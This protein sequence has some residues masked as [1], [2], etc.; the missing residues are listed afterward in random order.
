MEGGVTP[1]NLEKARNNLREEVR[2]KVGIDIFD[3]NGRLKAVEGLFGQDNLWGRVEKILATS[4]VPSQQTGSVEQNLRTLE[5]CRKVIWR[6]LSFSPELRQ[7]VDNS[8]PPLQNFPWTRIETNPSTGDPLSQFLWTNNNQRQSQM[9]DCKPAVDTAPPPQNALS[10]N[11]PNLA[12]VSNE[13]IPATAR[14][15]IGQNQNNP[16]SLKHQ[17]FPDFRFSLSNYSTSQPYLLEQKPSVISFNSD[18]ISLLN[19]RTRNFRRYFLGVAE[20]NRTKLFEPSGLLE[21]FKT[22]SN[23]R[24]K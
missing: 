2:K 22:N 20:G 8:S 10:Q 7:A 12:Q 16:F 17:P 19:D 21:E 11:T 4:G 6:G 24:I 23:N 5:D 15:F 1:Q 9:P 18:Q 3:K 13:S 14:S